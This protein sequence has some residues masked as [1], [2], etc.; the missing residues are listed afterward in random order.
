LSDE[1]LRPRNSD[2]S[3]RRLGVVLAIATAIAA[4]AIL[5]DNLAAIGRPSFYPVAAGR[6]L[7]FCYSWALLSIP[8]VRLTRR[9]PISRRPSAIAI[10]VIAA[11]CFSAVQVSALG[12][13]I[14]ISAGAEPVNF[15][16]A[17]LPIVYASMIIYAGVVAVATAARYR[18]E[19]Q[20]AEEAKLR[21]ERELATAQLNALR[22]QLQPHFLFNVMNSI[23]MLVRKGSNAEAVEMI[24]SL[25]DMLRRLLEEKRTCIPFAEELELTRRYLALE[26]VRFA[27]P[28]SVTLDIDP[29]TENALVPPLILQPIVENSVR[30]AFTSGDDGHLSIDSRR[31]HSCLVLTVSDDGAGSSSGSGSGF[32]IGLQ[33]TRDRLRTLYGGASDIRIESAQGKGTVVT[34]SLPLEYAQVHAHASR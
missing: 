28:F 23:A 27:H 31:D 18:T 6:T 34:I 11:L 16:V 5:F 8:V 33:N 32:G 13:A 19:S 4:L 17:G 25:S 7:L 12:T 20:A 15:I 30:H 29:A 3:Y 21:L 26:R 2:W 22:M 24:V 14:A 9:V 10:H 1:R